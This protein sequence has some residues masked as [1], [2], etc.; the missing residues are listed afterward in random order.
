MIV[1]IGIDILCVSRIEAIV[2]R[3]SRFTGRFAR[4]ILSDREI[5]YFGSTVA[6]QEDA[7]QVK[8]L[9]TRWCLKEAIYKAAYPQQTLRWSDVTIVKTGPKPTMDVRWGP[10]L[11]NAQAHVSLSHDGGM[12]AGVVVVETS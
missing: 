9:A 1:G 4:R 3:G 6:T 12:L 8:Y 7:A 2:R 5:S 10:E 11:A